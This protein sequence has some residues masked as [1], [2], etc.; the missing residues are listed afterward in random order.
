MSRHQPVRLGELLRTDFRT[1]T[2]GDVL[3]TRMLTSLQ[4]DYRYQPARLAIALS[5]ADPK[6]PAVPPE[7]LGKPIRGETLFGADEAEVGLWVS[8]IVEHA[9]LDAPSRRDVIDLVAG[10]WQRG[11]RAV[12]RQ[13]QAWK[14][15]PHEFIA[16][17]MKAEARPS[18]APADLAGSRVL[19]K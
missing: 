18:L 4:L 11:A 9:G 10:H 6:P 3:N 8:L 2:E 19:A 15:P 5:L 1:S 17:L 16:T 7:L 12:S 13:S 14:G